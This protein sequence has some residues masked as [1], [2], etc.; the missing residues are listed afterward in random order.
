MSSPAVVAVPFSEIDSANAEAFAAWLG[1][2]RHIDSLVLD[3]RGVTFLDSSAIRAL[4]LERRAREH[5]RSVRLQHV[6]SGVQRVLEICGLANAFC[7]SPA[8][9][10]DG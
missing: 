9:A 10:D 4:V 6:S 2:H 7:G 3:M 5:P 8:M 1:R